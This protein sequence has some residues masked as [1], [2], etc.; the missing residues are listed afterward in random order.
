MD[1]EMFPFYLSKSE[2]YC[3]QGPCRITGGSHCNIYVVFAK[4]FVR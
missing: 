1:V 2:S 4:K 3:L